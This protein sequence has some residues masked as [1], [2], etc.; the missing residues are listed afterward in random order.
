MIAATHLT[1]TNHTLLQNSRASKENGERSTIARDQLFYH[2]SYWEKPNKRNWSKPEWKIYPVCIVG[3]AIQMHTKNHHWHYQ[4]ISMT[5]RKRGENWC[6]R[7]ELNPGQPN[8]T[9]LMT[10]ANNC[11]TRL[12]QTIENVASRLFFTRSL[13][14]QYYAKN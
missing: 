14:N 6:P 11:A 9:V 2:D 7:R 4:I 5:K 8:F 13:L 10:G 1:N 3:I 12:P